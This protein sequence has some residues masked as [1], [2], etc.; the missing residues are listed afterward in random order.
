[1]ANI[2]EKH[3]QSEYQYPKPLIELHGKPLIEYVIENLLTIQG[4]K[5]IFFILNEG[6]CA[7]YHLDNTISL[8]CPNAKIIYLKNRTSGAVC[9]SLLAIDQIPAKEECVVVNADQIFHTDLNQ[10]I[11]NFKKDKLD[12][13]VITFPSVHPRWSYALCESGNKVIQFAEKNPISK[14][15]IAGFYYFKS[16]DLFV[17]HA[18]KT[19][20]DDDNLNGIF[21][22]SSV[23]NQLI[24]S[25][26]KVEQHRI[27]SNEY[28]SL[29]S[30]Q[31]IKE[32]E[33]FLNKHNI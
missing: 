19:M 10:I 33:D 12:G 23:L 16:Y 4:V 1:M 31:K 2:E 8:L 3:D 15:A 17:E 14:N 32:F 20:A 9:T 11:K 7:K 24:L 29:Y 22:T 27:A 28:I 6:M 13:A 18:F 5:H 25:G 21:Y 30:T 26:K